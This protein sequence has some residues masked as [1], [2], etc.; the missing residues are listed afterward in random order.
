M[1]DKRNMNSELP[2]IFAFPGD[3]TTFRI[4]WFGEVSYVN[5][6]EQRSQPSIQVH[7]AKVVDQAV[8]ADGKKLLDPAATNRGWSSI[9]RHVS[10]GCLPRLRIGDVWEH[11]T[12]L[13]EPD[14][15]V[16]TFNNLQIDNSTTRLVKAGLNKN[17]EGFLI[18]L[19][20]H[21]WHRK[22]TQSYCIEVDL[23]D[24]RRLMVPCVELIRFYFG[25][26]SSLIRRI[27]L[28]HL[29][30]DLLFTEYEFNKHTGLLQLKLAPGLYGASAADVGRICLNSAAWHAAVLVGKSLLTASTA[31]QPAFPPTIFPFEGTTNLTVSGKWVSFPGK[32]NT[33]F[34]VFNIRSCTHAFP[35]SNLK[36]TMSI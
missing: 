33:T 23:N 35:F 2:R 1:N 13:L 8:L 22:C 25:S 18:P 26:C 17:A 19:E 14:Y 27:F 15:Q 7:L 4:S 3:W 10:I 29:S 20:E 31:G 5:R 24:G 36:Y 12:L 6:S 21:P 11:K 34:V 9:Y 32:E 16:E 30:K 28:P